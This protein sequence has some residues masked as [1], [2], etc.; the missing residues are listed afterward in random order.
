MP[1]FIGKSDDGLLI[2]N[3]K[4]S[5]FFLFFL[6]FGIDDSFLCSRQQ[7]KTFLYLITNRQVGKAGRDESKRTK[8]VMEKFGSLEFRVLIYSGA[9]TGISFVH[10]ATNDVPSR[11]SLRNGYKTSPRRGNSFGIRFQSS[12]N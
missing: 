12:C 10:V 9:R 6:L 3:I 7:K 11:S 4:L 8:N 2:V 5:D 1:Q